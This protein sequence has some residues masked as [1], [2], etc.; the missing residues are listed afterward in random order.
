[1]PCIPRGGK[2]ILARER[3]EPAS[4][5]QPCKRDWIEPKTG[6]RVARSVHEVASERIV[7]AEPVEK[8]VDVMQADGGEVRAGVSMWGNPGDVMARLVREGF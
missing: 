1:M 4:G 8:P 3:S 6:K 2:R 7:G 5:R